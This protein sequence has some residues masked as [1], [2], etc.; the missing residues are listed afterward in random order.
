ML[1]SIITLTYNSAKTIEKTLKSIRNQD[2]KNIES[3]FIDN[4]SEDGTIEILK[5]YSNKKTKMFSE[6]DNG[7]TNA[8][9]KGIKKSSGDIIGFLHS[10]DT[11]NNNHCISDIV[12][13]F[14]NYEVNF[15]YSDLTYLSKKKQIRVWKAD[16]TEGVKNISYLKKKLLFGWMPP[17]PTVYIKREFLE[18]IGEYD[19]N[20]KISFD[21]DY[22]LRALK[23]NKIKPYYLKKNLINM[24]IGGNSNKSLKNVIKK[25]LEDYIIIKKNLKYGLFTLLSKNF[26]KISQ[27]SILFKRNQ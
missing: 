7:I 2:Y 17:H 22:L 1:I 4:L 9:N 19:E 26:R 6:K 23:S 12:K 15:V 27:F 10:D 21:Y 14:E 5:K 20:F 16:T 3:I 24:Q 25:M 18:E 13:V 8:F 11:F